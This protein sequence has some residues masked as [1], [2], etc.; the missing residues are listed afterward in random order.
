MGKDALK[1]TKKDRMNQ[2]RASMKKPTALSVRDISKYRNDGEW[3][4][5][6]AWGCS[7]DFLKMQGSA[8]KR[9]SAATGEDK[10]TELHVNHPVIV[11]KG[12]WIQSSA[13]FGIPLVLTAE[14][15]AGGGTPGTIYVSLF[16]T[17]GKKD[18]GLTMETG[19]SGGAVNIFQDKD[20]AVGKPFKL[21]DNSKWH[22]IQIS[23]DSD[24]EVKYLINGKEVHSDR[25]KLAQGSVA[26]IGGE[27]SVHIRNV[28]VKV[29]ATSSERDKRKCIAAAEANPQDGGDIYFKPPCPEFTCRPSICICKCPG[30]ACESTPPA[31]A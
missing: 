30:E 23:I 22:A 19:A 31:I 28:D 6:P 25:T 29:L 27:Q 26:F 15:R 13:L 18:G 4:G 10:K 24:G 14:I 17:N 3:I 21:E 2:R 16:N 8:P 1:E 12:Q 9:T 7:G 11:P 20:T 5:K